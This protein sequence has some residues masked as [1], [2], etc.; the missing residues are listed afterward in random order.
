MTEAR[1]KTLYIIY[2][3]A[4][5]IVSIALPVWAICEKF[6]IWH[7]RNGTEYTIGVG[8]IL[9]AFVVVVVFRKTVFDF[10]RDKLDLRHAP[11]VI[12]W[13]ALTIASYVLVFLGD[14]MRDMS[15]VFIMGIVGSAIGTLLT[16]ISNKYKKDEDDG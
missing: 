16:Y 10:L 2:K 9:I 13:C 8:V 15:T 1:R 3:I 11:P 5:I 12:I 4:S 7:D 6:P 14:V